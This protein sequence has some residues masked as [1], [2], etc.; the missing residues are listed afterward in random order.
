LTDKGNRVLEDGILAQQ[1]WLDDLTATLSDGEKES[2]MV[3]LEILIDKTRNL[4]Q[5]IKIE[6]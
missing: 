2:I 1:R 5:P 6:S 3:A 4:K